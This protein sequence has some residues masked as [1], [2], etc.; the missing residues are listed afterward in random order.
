MEYNEE[1][2]KKSANKKAMIMW[3]F[4]AIV[5]TIAYGI[6]A[7]KGARTI[8]YYTVFLIMCWGPFL[9]GVVLLKV[10]GMAI[11]YY[12]DIV[13]FGYGFFY[14][15]VLLT[16]KNA[17]P[18]VY[19][20]P[21]TSML[22]LFK[23][24]NFL[25]RCGVANL[26]VMAVIV[27]KNYTSGMNSSEDIINYEIQFLVLVLCYM[28]YILSV[29]HL[30]LSD[31]ALIGSIEGNLKRVVKTIEQ[32]KDASTLVVDGVTVVRELADENQE[33]ANNVV[34][35]METLAQNNNFLHEKTISSLDMTQKINNQ[36]ENVAQSIEKMVTLVQES[37]T[38]AST[39]SSKLSGLVDTTK[40]MAQLASEV[41]SVL[42]EFKKEFAMVKE[43]TGTIEGITS[44][45]NLLALNASIEAA[46]AG[47][48]GKGFAVVADEIRNLSMGTQNSSNSIMNAL[49]HLEETSDRMTKAIN[50]TLELIHITIEKM[51]EVNDSVNSITEDSKQIGSDIKVIDSAMSDVEESNRNMVDNMKQICDVMELMTDSIRNAEDTTKV[52]RSKYEETSTNVI[53]IEKVVGQL[54]EQLGA[55]GF[56][57]VKDL[58][59]GMKTT[60]IEV[61]TQPPKEYKAEII[62]VTEDTIIT[63]R[64]TAEGSFAE[65]DKHK[66]YN[67]QVVVDSE[68]YDWEDIR[69]VE[70]KDGTYRIVLSANPSVVNRRKYPRMPLSNLCSIK[71][72]TSNHS[73]EGKMVNISANG[74]AFTTRAI[75]VKEAKGN[76]VSIEVDNF[77]LLEN[78]KLDGYIIR[79]S[80]NDGEYIV[81]CRML[82]DNKAIMDFV[83]KNYHQ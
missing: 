69:I 65:I 22:M 19:I 44:Q 81:G 53:N 64:F 55:G 13:A 31:G 27:V 76:Q 8:P 35:S 83:N 70:Q 11:S 78:E 10:K 37:V 68:L 58:K 77:A 9:L 7:V 57:G 34:G 46:R 21:I 36:V 73:Y 33:G 50:G 59:L 5:L 43:E 63:E 72:A 40:T 18:F 32:V 54:V 28:G 79:V 3:L 49:G 39:S 66:K 75:E 51:A 12:K 24:R 82:E 4:M 45:T 20:F 47:D 26:F 2:F 41:E 80:Q 67:L 71:L 60:L 1:V 61:G 16:T 17:L 6:E 56:M 38:H 48:A 29:S 74:F 25:I 42:A 23:N 14:F 15:F 30:N 52:M 62:E